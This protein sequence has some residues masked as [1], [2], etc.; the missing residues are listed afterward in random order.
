MYR[1]VVLEDDVKQAQ[2]LAKMVES[3]PCGTSLEVSYCTSAAELASLAAAR[4]ISIALLDIVLAGNG[5]SGVDL[6]R[7]LFPDGSGVQVIYVTGY[8]EDYYLDVY[9]TDHVYLLAKPVDPD[10]L[11]DALHRAVAR[12][13]KEA[14][15]PFAVSF[16]G[17]MRL[18]RPEK[19]LFVESDRR[20]VRINLQ[21]EV[22]ET[23]ASLANMQERLPGSFLRCHKSFL[24][25]ASYIETVGQSHITLLGGVEVPVSQRYRQRVRAELEARVRTLL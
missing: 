2:A 21:D 5:S 16:R 8:A 22:I 15:V 20:K 3:T 18:I 4:D 1:V 23:Y 10:K 14:S 7:R 25:N 12:L 11:A 17:R 24:V 13:D 6:A 19:V 9:E